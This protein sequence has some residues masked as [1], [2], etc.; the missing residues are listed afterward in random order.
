MKKKKFNSQTQKSAYLFIAPSLIILSIFVF[1][2]LIAS[3]IISLLNINIFMNDISFAGLKNFSRLLSDSRVWNATINTF[4]YA[5]LE[6]P[7]QIG[8]A[9][10]LLM[11]M[12]R[13]S[14]YKG[15]F[16]LYT[17]FLLYVQ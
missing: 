14:K 17:I 1:V 3:F 2:P 16:V 7:L 4:Y 13:N 8:L 9:L 6:V 11:F 12:D 10:L 15:Y 5:L